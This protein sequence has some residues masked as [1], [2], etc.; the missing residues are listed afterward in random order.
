[1]TPAGTFTFIDQFKVE[2]TNNKNFGPLRWPRRQWHSFKVV[3][4]SLSP[5][6]CGG[7]HNKIFWSVLSFVPPWWWRRW[8]CT[9]LSVRYFKLWISQWKEKFLVGSWRLLDGIQKSSYKFL[10]N[11]LAAEMNFNRNNHIID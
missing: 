9:L 7:M 8:W 5:K 4:I 2:M 11:I 1:M 6:S 10:K 3:Q